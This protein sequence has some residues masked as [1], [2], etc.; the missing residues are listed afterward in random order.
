VGHHVFLHVGETDIDAV[1]PHATITHCFVAKKDFTAARAKQF[2][3][4]R[5][6]VSGRR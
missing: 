6:M 2:F 5:N 1:K 4:L 3:S